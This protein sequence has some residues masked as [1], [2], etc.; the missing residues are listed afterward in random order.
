MISRG[1]MYSRGGMNSGPARIRMAMDRG[2][3]LRE[4]C[5]LSAPIITRMTYLMCSPSLIMEHQSIRL[6][7]IIYFSSSAYGHVCLQSRALIDVRFVSI[8]YPWIYNF[9]EIFD[10]VHL[11]FITSLSL[12]RLIIKN[13]TPTIDR[14]ITYGEA[15]FR[16]CVTRRKTYCE[17]RNA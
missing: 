3:L 8:F 7:C 4:T 15:P 6:L 10:C 12:E 14:D 11:A 5:P 2:I 16:H 13:Y 1:N 17:G 9:M